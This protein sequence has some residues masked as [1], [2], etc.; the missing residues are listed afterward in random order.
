MHACMHACAP[1]DT[2]RER[3]R[4]EKRKRREGGGREREN[5]A[6]VRE[7]KERRE[8]GR[9][10]ERRSHDTAEKK[11]GERERGRER[12][13]EKVGGET[14]SLAPPWACGYRVKRPKLR[15]EA[16]LLQRSLSWNR[17]AR[18]YLAYLRRCAADSLSSSLFLLSS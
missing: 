15:F 16:A 1:C 14:R 17:T 8:R 13:K 6:N 10:L 3:A 9:Q 18:D 11:S 2:E 12:K 4:D 5:S 7:E